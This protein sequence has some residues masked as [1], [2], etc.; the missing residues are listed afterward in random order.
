MVEFAEGVEMPF[1]YKII[2]ESDIKT[3]PSS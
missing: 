3:F 2:D 1:K